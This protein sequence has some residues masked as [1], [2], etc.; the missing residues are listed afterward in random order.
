MADNEKNEEKG[1]EEPTPSS[2]L[3]GGVDLVSLL[4]LS[5]QL[6][7]LPDGATAVKVTLQSG[8]LEDY[9]RLMRER[10]Q[11]VARGLESQTALST[12]KAEQP[13]PGPL[14]SKPKFIRESAL[15][16]PAET[17]IGK[18][19]GEEGTPL[20]AF[21]ESVT[22]SVID[23]Q[24]EIDVRSLEYA[25]ELK[26][27]PLA[28]MHFSIPNVHAEVKMGFNVSDPANLLVR[29]FG[30]PEERSEYGESTVGFDIA[31]S[32][33]PPGVDFAT[34]IPAFLVVEPE[35]SRVLNAAGI[36]QAEIAGAVLLK[37]A[38]DAKLVI[39]KTTYLAWAPRGDAVTI[40]RIV[41][42]QQAAQH[43][44]VPAGD[45]AHWLADLADVLNTW[46]ASVK[47]GG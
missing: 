3:V 7:D 26:G 15:A 42:G 31:A 28:P 32:A 18:A 45:T 38:A 34:P 21:F 33:P 43:F 10:A 5:Q 17:K 46:I 11:S 29:L 22:K 41:Q 35:R 8:I 2:L 40:H 30:S 1:A 12:M 4:D 25:R 24:R 16:R 19:T 6:S 39:G 13:A 20:S 14:P 27:T 23:A 37:N 36:P 44:D 9:F 47:L